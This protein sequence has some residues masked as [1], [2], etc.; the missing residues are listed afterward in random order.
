MDFIDFN[1]YW[2]KKQE[3]KIIEND[4]TYLYIDK[5]KI[6][7]TMNTLIGNAKKN[8]ILLLIFIQNKY[9]Y[10]TIKNLNL[11]LTDSNTNNNSKIRI[12]FDSSYN[13]K[14]LLSTNSTNLLNIQ[15]RKIVKPLR[16][17]MIAFIIE[18]QHLIFIDLKQNMDFNQLLAIY[19]TTNNNNN[20]T[21]YNLFEDLW[22]LSELKEQPT[23][24]KENE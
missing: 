24:Y 6:K 10:N 18:H 13:L 23:K 11:L 1:V 15:Y 22:T 8:E 12:L 16:S 19:S 7:D 2:K 9:N 14:L 17:D 20:S 5:E 4:N 21:F 3:L